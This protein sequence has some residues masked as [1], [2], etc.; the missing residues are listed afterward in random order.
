MDLKLDFLV[1]GSANDHFLSNVAFLNKSLK[2]LGGIY[3]NARLVVA[4]G[5]W[6]VPELPVRWQPYLEGVDIIWSNP[7]KKPNPSYNI[8]HFDRFDHIRPDADIAVICDADV[9]FMRPFDETLALIARANAVGGVMAHYH[10]PLKGK[11]GDPAEDWRKVALATIG[12]EI[13]RNHHYLFGQAPD[14]PRIYAASE[15]PL[16]PFYI[17]YGILIGTP[18]QLQQ[19]HAR[20]RQLIPIVSELVD[21]YFA[22]QVALALACADLSLPTV[23]LPA[24]FNFPNRPEA[25]E[26]QPGEMDQVVMFHYLFEENFNRSHLFA[27]ETAYD[28]FMEKELTGADKLFQNYIRATCGNIYPFPNTRTVRPHAAAEPIGSALGY[29]K[30]GKICG[31]IKSRQPGGASAFMTSIKRLLASFSRR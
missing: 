14:E 13:D 21:P 4:L 26:L 23:A 11:R 12:R 1:P 8:Q 15:R 27:E 5:E 30:G 3:A 7:E 18:R 6:D 29:A 31:K 19:M 25:D 10:F 22:A 2:A 28:A 17:N 24:R 16:T 20:E 9:C